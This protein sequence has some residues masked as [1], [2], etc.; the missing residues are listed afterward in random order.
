MFCYNFF[1]G[2]VKTLFS[3]YRQERLS[4]QSCYPCKSIFYPLI[5]LFFSSLFFVLNLK[6]YNVNFQYLVLTKSRQFRWSHW[7][8]RQMSGRLRLTV[9]CY[10]TSLDEGRSE[11][12]GE[13]SWVHQMDN[14][15]IGRWPLSVSRV[16]LLQFVLLYICWSQGWLQKCF[17]WGERGREGVIQNYF[18]TNAHPPLLHSRLRAG[19]KKGGKGANKQRR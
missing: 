15:E 2:L 6:V 13:L 19:K 16:S 8:Q 11:P 3:H 4:R 9:S 10:K 5:S 18:S 1:L 17:I 7:M 14:L 12:C